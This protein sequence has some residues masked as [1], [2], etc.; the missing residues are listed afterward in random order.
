MEVNQQ[1]FK[2]TVLRLN[3]RA[4][5]LFYHLFLW[6]SGGSAITSCLLL[7]SWALEATLIHFLSLMRQPQLHASHVSLMHNLAEFRH[8]T[9]SSIQPLPQKLPVSSEGDVV[10]MEGLGSEDLGGESHHGLA[11][12]QLSSVACHWMQLQLLFKPPP[13]LDTAWGLHISFWSRLMLSL[14][15]N[16]KRFHL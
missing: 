12:T 14:E 4:L 1:F 13:P 6:L 8:Q 10:K 7:L 11:K 16:C 9:V 15:M 2:V 5:G 3:L